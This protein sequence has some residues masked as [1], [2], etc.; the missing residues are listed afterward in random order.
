MN[1]A[2]RVLFEGE[3]L[4]PEELLLLGDIHI[5]Q[6]ILLAVHFVHVRVRG[7]ADFTFK[8]FP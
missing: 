7:L 2:R 1:H 5:D 6:A 4:E 3:G 8:L